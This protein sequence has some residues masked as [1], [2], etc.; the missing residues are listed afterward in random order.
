MVEDRWVGEDRDRGKWHCQS[1]KIVDIWM[2]WEE[3]SLG[4]EDAL[5]FRKKN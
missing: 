3:K 5:R 4:K 1:L 2:N